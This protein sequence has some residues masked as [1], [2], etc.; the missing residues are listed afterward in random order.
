MV[1]S[2]HGYKSLRSFYNKKYTRFIYTNY[3]IAVNKLISKYLVVFAT[4]HV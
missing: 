1:L 3:T 4:K 2:T